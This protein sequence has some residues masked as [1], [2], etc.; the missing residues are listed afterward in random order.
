MNSAEVLKDP[1]TGYARDGYVIQSDGIHLT[2]EAIGVLFDYIRTHSY[3]TEGR[4]PGADRY[5]RASQR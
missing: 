1:E 5:P 4:P 3:I 2:E